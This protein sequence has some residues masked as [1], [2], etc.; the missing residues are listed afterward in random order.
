[1]ALG[2]KGTPHSNGNSENG[3]SGPT[4]EQLIKGAQSLSADM[5]APFFAHVGEN[6]IYGRFLGM[7][8]MKGAVKGSPFYF[9][10]KTML[11]TLVRVKGEK[12]KTVEVPAGTVVSMGHTAGN[13]VFK[14]E[15]WPLVQAGAT[16]EVGNKLGAKQEKTKSGYDVW[17]M[18]PVIKVIEGPKRPVLK[19]A[20]PASATG[21][22]GGGGED[23]PF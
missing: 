3:S 6:A 1:M 5:S 20:P 7:F 23:L 17:P 10:V 4:Y 2:K 22:D 13:G 16:V 14:D 15:V 21:D 8:E 18:K 12:G 19:A 11:P 9:Q